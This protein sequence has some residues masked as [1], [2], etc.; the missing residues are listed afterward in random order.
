MN[1]SIKQYYNELAENYDHSRF[2]NTY[3]KFINEQEVR[4]LNKYVE[5][6]NKGRNLDLACGTGRFLDYATHGIDISEEMLKISRLKNADK[7]LQL[8]DADDLPFENNYF[9]RVISFHLMMH[10][11]QLKFE[12]ILNEVKR[13]TKKDGLFIFDIPSALRR[14]LLNYSAKSWHGGYQFSVKYLEAL[15]ADDWKLVNF[16]GVSFFP[17]HRIPVKLRSKFLKMDNYFCESRFKAY[18]SYLIFI[19]QKK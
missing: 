5:K 4:I 7:I 11:D 8:A 9:D 17:L 12:E 2:G 1:K 10:L 18:A 15:I 6:N 19:L 16:H 14:N 3:G 13:V